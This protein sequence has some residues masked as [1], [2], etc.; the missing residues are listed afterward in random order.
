MEGSPAQQLHHYACVLCAV[1]SVA[2]GG[3]SSRVGM[4]GEAAIAQQSCTI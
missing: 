4:R 3:S 2:A 1:H